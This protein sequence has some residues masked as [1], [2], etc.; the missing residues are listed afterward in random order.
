MLGGHSDGQ[1]V[2]RRCDSDSEE[3]GLHPVIDGG[4]RQHPSCA[5]QN[6][7]LVRKAIHGLFHFVG[8]YPDVAPR[9]KRQWD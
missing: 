5:N 4:P 7:G 3:D 2:G 8:Y 9:T 6:Q 1:A